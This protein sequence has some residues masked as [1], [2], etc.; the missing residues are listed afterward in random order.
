MTKNKKQDT[1]AE[2]SPTVDEVDPLA[3]PGDASDLPATWERPEGENLPATR[4]QSAPLDREDFITPKL[5]LVQKTGDLSVLFPLGSWVLNKEIPLTKAL[6]DPLQV[7]VLEHPHKFFMEH[8]VYDPSNT[9][10]ARTFSSV[11]ELEAEGLTLEWDN[12]NNI[13]ATADRAARVLLLILKPAGL[14]TESGFGM[15]IDGIGLCA[16]ASWLLVNTSY[17]SAARRIFTAEKL[18]LNG[19]PIYSLVWTLKSVPA[20]VGGY[21]IVVPQLSTEKRLTD[22]AQAA[23]QKAFSLA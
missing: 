15:T 14:E 8:R 2:A 22:E 13:R 18:D 12:K 20:K 23:L 19:K 1:E 9:T 17:N 16:V 5:H 21:N 7:V 11:E 3:T 10:P 6:G 4:G